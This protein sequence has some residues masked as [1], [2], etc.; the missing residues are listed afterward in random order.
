[1]IAEGAHWMK[2][3]ALDPLQLTIHPFKSMFEFFH[4]LKLASSSHLGK[5]GQFGLGV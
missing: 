1:M 5:C 4:E 2:P 3:G